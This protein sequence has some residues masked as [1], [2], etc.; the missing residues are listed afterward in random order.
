MKLFVAVLRQ[1]RRCVI[2]VV[3]DRILRLLEVEV[4]ENYCTCAEEETLQ[5]TIVAKRV[6][7]RVDRPRI[8]H[9]V[10]VH[11]K[12]DLK[13]STLARLVGYLRLLVDLEELELA[14]RDAAD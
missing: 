4:A 14:A 5:A 8:V 1:R 6:E 10:E 3:H 7:D 13:G 12:H 2:Q 9:P 11:L